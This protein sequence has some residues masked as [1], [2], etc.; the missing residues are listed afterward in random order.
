MRPYPKLR[1]EGISHT[2]EGELRGCPLSTTKSAHVHTHAYIY[3]HTSSTRTGHTKSTTYTVTTRSPHGRHTVATHTY[4]TRTYTTDS[5][6]TDST[7]SS[8]HTQDCHFHV[9]TI[10]VDSYVVQRQQDH[11]SHET[12]GH[13]H[14]RA[15]VHLSLVDACNL[16]H[17]HRG[18][19]EDHRLPHVLV[20]SVG[21]AHIPS[22]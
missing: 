5:K 19:P 10:T 3:K 14:G 4:F 22:F 18:T 21:P 20:S 13:P 16:R 7:S 11:R 12:S 2:K 1:K 6:H 17:G 15:G 9:R 8:P